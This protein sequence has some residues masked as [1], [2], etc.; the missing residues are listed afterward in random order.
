MLTRLRHTW[1]DLRNRLDY[2][3]RQRLHWQRH[4][5]R[6][7]NEAKAN[8]YRHL[9]AAARQA[10]EQRVERL[11]ADYDLEY[12]AGHSPADN[13][14][15]N[16]YYLDLLET[17]F[18]RGGVR[19]PQPVLAADIGVSHWFYVQAYA[20]L[21]RGWQTETPRQISLHGYEADPYRMYADFAS[22]YDHA[23]AHLEGVPGSEYHPQAFAT[24]A[25][26]FD[27]V[28]LLFPFVFISDHLDW[29][30]PGS[31]FQPESLLRSAWESLK[32]GGWLVIVNQGEAEHAA[33]RRA[34]D[35][36]GAPVAAA[37]RHDSTLYTYDLPRY[38]LVCAKPA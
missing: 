21:L 31:H 1:Q 10:A 27:L 8:L 15:E 12:L 34:I 38:V 24:Q 25:G 5:Y 6:L 13:F 33:Q 29:G 16:L 30:L 32:A 35:A 3:L 18:E 20:A 4:G 26:R 2:P 9:P 23:L 28:S 14:R 17:A 36:L 7:A 19:L 11:C 22:R 37:Y